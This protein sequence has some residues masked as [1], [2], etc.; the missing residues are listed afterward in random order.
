M[1]RGTRAW[2]RWVL[3]ILLATGWALGADAVLV[4]LATFNVLFGVGT[5]GST[6]YNAVKSVL[7]RINPD[8]IAFQELMDTDYE[9]WVV[10]AADLGYPHLAYGPSYGPLTGSQRLGFM[11]RHPITE[12]FELTEYPG[13]T[14]LTRYPLRVAIQVPGALNPLVL[15]TVHLKASSGSVNQF[16]RGIEGRR[17]LSNLV[18]YAETNPLT[19]EY[20]ILGDFNEDVADSQTAQ[21]NALPSGLPSAYTLGADVV[22]PVP[23]RLFPTDRFAPGGLEPLHPYQEDSSD[24][25]TYGT[26]G[27]L[28]YLLFSEEIRNSPYGAPAGEIYNSTRDDGTGGLPKYGS[29]LAAATSGNASDHLT[30]FADFNLIDGLPCVNPVLFLSEILAHPT[31]PGASYIELHN[32]GATGLNITNYAVVVYFDGATPV[33]L[34]VSGSLG[35]GASYVLAGNAIAYQTAFGLVPNQVAT[36][37]LAL[38]GNDVVALLSPAQQ[39]SD[40]FGVIGEPRVPP[41]SRPAGAIPARRSNA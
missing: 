6:E 4:R 19:T 2:R 21:F 30:V 41:T 34:P 33:T 39:I 32:S 38:D 8:I 13:A 36:N 1:V 14:E 31:V 16:R 28:D 10:L 17:I 11:S 5:P 12:A 22:F 7:Q 26:G 25:S 9:N 35:A 37:L 15:Y 40:L 23:Y 24:D 3:G 18:A 29:P 27:R 20:V